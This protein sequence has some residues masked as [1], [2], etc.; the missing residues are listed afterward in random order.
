MPDVEQS[1][2]LFLGPCVILF[3]VFVFFVFCVAFFG[4]ML[5]LNSDIVS[6]VCFEF[7]AHCTTHHMDPRKKKEWLVLFFHWLRTAAQ[8][9]ETVRYSGT[10]GKLLPNAGIAQ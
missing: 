6:S 8:P 3:I 4:D 9:I 1:I 2:I 10:L 5:M 7:H